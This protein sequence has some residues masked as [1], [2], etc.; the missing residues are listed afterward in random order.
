MLRSDGEKSNPA[1][2]RNKIM[3]ISTPKKNVAWTC[4]SLVL[5]LFLNSRLLMSS[6]EKKSSTALWNIIKKIYC[7]ILFFS[8]MMSC[9]RRFIGSKVE[10]K[11][12]TNNTRGFAK[13]IYVRTMSE[14]QQQRPERETRDVIQLIEP[15]VL[16]F[17]HLPASILTWSLSENALPA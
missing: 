16:R 10:W 6:P 3:Q 2:S 8:P 14:F 15:I 1:T 7:S 12:F 11:Y 9:R 17:E 4:R 13:D 5:F